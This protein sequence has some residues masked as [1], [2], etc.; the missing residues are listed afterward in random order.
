M[1]ISKAGCLQKSLRQSGM[2]NTKAQIIHKIFFKSDN[3]MKVFFL[4]LLLGPLV[5]LAMH[6]KPIL[7]IPMKIGNNNFQSNKHKN[8]VV[9]SASDTYHSSINM[10]KKSKELMLALGIIQIVQLLRYTFQKP[11]NTWIT[12]RVFSLLVAFK[13]Y[14]MV[15]SVDSYKHFPC[16]EL[17][18]ITKK[19][20]FLWDNCTTYIYWKVII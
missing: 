10:N 14:T 12:F 19:L 7:P 5:T 1:E 16:L 6:C 11:P 18:A 4:L 9:A 17:R 8:I 13:V 2:K 3:I 20:D 15:S